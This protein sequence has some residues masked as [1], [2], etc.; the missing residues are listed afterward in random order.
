M[1]ASNPPAPPVSAGEKTVMVRMPVE[2]ATWAAA[3]ARREG[4]DLSKKIRTLLRRWRAEVEVAEA[5]AEAQRQAEIQAA[6]AAALRRKGQAPNTKPQ[7]KR[8]KTPGKREAAR[9][10]GSPAR[11]TACA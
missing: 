10:R 8:S 3:Q 5:A 6:I 1:P 11:S 4:G 7:S 2:L 9:S